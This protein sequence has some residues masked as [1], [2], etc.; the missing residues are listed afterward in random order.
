MG[1]KKQYLKSKPECKVTC[2]LP[3]SEA[4]NA[5]KVTVVGEFNNWDTNANPMKKMKDKTFSASFTLKK[6]HEYQFRYLVNEESWENDKA[7]DKYVP[8]PYGDSQNSVIVV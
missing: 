8:T 2:T 6:G 1:L 5:Q 4:Q 3:K 7:A